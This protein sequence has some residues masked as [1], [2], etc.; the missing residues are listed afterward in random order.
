[1]YRTAILLTFISLMLLAGCGPGDRYVRIEGYAQGGTYHVT[2]HAPAGLRDE[3]LLSLI[4][5]RLQAIDF[6]LSGYNKGSLLSRLNA[7]E[8]LPLD[9]FF[10]GCFSRSRDI[11]EESGGAFDPSAAPLF[12]LWGFGFSDKGAVTRD[13]IDS[14]MAFV[15]MDLFRLERRGDGVHLVKSDPRCRLNFN[16]IAQGWSADVIGALLDSLGCTDYLVDIGREI[17]SRGNNASGGPWRVGLDRPSDG[18][19][20]E[21]RDLQAVIDVHDCGIVTSGNYRKFYVEDGRKYAH[22]IDPS[23]GRPVTHNLLSATV[24]AED[25]ATADAYATWLMVAGPERARAIVSAKPGV[26]ALLVYDADGRME[27]WQTENIKTE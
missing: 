11:W 20:D 13:A 10:I 1:M 17:R 4:D 12:D 23:T 19:F 3:R 14:I 7:G 8:D 2:C 9:T 21:G 15:G 16:A 22:T 18:N 26:E 25:S 24:I 5:E 6:S 27:T